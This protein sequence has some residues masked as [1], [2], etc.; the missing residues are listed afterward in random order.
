[1]SQENVEVTRRGI[2]AFNSG[3][4][5]TLAALSTDDLEIRPATQA[6]VEGRSSVY[7]GKSAWTSYFA[8]IRE[9]WE[10]WGIAE[11]EYYEGD[12]DRLA[13]IVRVVGIGAGSGARV[14]RTVGLAFRFRSGK[15]CRV[16]GYEEPREALEA[17]GFSE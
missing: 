17:V 12:N 1:M 6:A 10:E 13:A 9:I 8:F 14:E 11:A 15:F 7:R 16:D 2:E 4:T 3:N 5:E